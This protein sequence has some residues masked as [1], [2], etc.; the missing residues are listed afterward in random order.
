MFLFIFAVK[1]FIQLMRFFSYILVFILFTFLGCNDPNEY[2]IPTDFSDYLQRFEMEAAKRGKDFDLKNKG[3]I[4]EFAHLKNNYAG[5]THYE[6]P[7]RIEIDREYWNDISTYAGA[8][9]MKE[10]LIFHELGHGLLKRK[11]LNTSLVNGDWKS[12]MSGGTAVDNRKWNINYRGVRRD[13]YIDELFEENTE[14]PTFATKT[15]NIDTTGF[16]VKEFYSFDNE[17]NAG[18]K[19]KDSENYTTSLVDGKLKFESKVNKLYLVYAQTTVNVLTDFIFELMMEC[20]SA[21]NENY[22]GAIFG[23]L[24]D[25]SDGSTDPIEYFCIDNNQNMYVGNR[26]WYSYYVQLKKPSIIPKRNNHL[27]VIKINNMLFY[28]INGVYE[29]QTEMEVNQ[30]GN[31]LGF[32]VPSKQTVLVDSFKLSQRSSSNTKTFKIKN[33][34]TTQFGVKEIEPFSTHNHYKK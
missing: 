21:T 29:Y 14:V 28:Y 13:Y 25:N 23:Y 7:I 16:L 20:E 4:I 1:S 9:L 15:V 11:H 3:L 22:Y 19:I 26:S 18:W 6:N 33:N 32:L 24:A 10:C 31:Y 8:D 27:K 2:R 17:A 30:P 5:L 34:S 12:I